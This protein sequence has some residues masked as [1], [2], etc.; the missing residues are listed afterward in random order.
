M[1]LTLSDNLQNLAQDADSNFIPDGAERYPSYLKDPDVFGNTQ[2]RARY[3]GSTFIASASTTVILNFVFFDVG[4]TPNPELPLD[5][6]LGYPNVTVLQDPTVVAPGLITDFC[7]PLVANTT[8][9][10]ISKD[11]PNT[12]TGG[13]NVVRQNPP[14][15]GTFNFLN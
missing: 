14:S 4:V 9:F 8:V 13:G 7:T 1:P 6:R 12:G 15:D 10:A 11:N 5:P 2:P 3:F